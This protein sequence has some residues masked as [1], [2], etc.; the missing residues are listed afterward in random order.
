M[1]ANKYLYSLASVMSLILLSS[2]AQ[3]A[4]SMDRTRVVFDGGQKSISLNIS[5]NNK[6]LPYL[7]QAWIENEEG[8]KI[9]SPL[10][11]LPPVQRLEPGKSSQVKIESLPAI[12]NLPQDR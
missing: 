1:T 2:A 4:I 12:A 5:N 10:I 11:V 3:A 8:K 7:A 6:Q 9:Q